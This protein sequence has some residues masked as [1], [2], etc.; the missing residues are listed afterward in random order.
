MAIA[1]SL[2]AFSVALIIGTIY[3]NTRNIYYYALTVGVL[4]FLMP[5]LGAFSNHLLLK[6]F[7]YNGNRLLG[8]ILFIITISM[9]IDMNKKSNIIDKSSVFILALSV[10]LD[11]YFAG[12][13]IK[14]VS[15]HLA[16][17]F[18]L[19]SVTSFLFSI[20][21]CYL[22]IVGKSKL[23]QKATFLAIIIMLLLSV[24]YI[25]FN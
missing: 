8:I 13:G 9:I 10:S 12:I 21:G 2:D 16:L 7:V 17:V 14:A 25:L 1:L 5:I 23:G 3:G 19:F 20:I 6:N 4:H 11:S 18:G 22:G 24:K 15:N